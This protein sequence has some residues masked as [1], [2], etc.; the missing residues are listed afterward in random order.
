MEPR[1][2]GLRGLEKGRDEARPGAHEAAAPQGRRLPPALCQAQARGHQKALRTGMRR[3][4]RMMRLR[5]SG[6]G[7]A[8]IAIHET[9]E[10]AVHDA[11]D[12][13]DFH[14]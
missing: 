12:F 6:I 1:R 9:H 14:V 7:N 5:V 8:R 11:D 10:A 3:L 2:D 4:C 13:P